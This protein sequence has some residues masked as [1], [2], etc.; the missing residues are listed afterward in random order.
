VELQKL[1][2]R[3]ELRWPGSPDDVRPFIW[4]QA[5]AENLSVDVEALMLWA[6]RL[7]VDKFWA[8]INNGQKT[9]LEAE[10]KKTTSRLRLSFN[11]DACRQLISAM[12]FSDIVRRRLCND[13]LIAGKAYFMPE[14]NRQ[15]LQSAI[16]NFELVVVPRD[17]APLRELMKQD[18]E[19]RDRPDSHYWLGIR[20]LRPSS[21]ATARSALTDAMASES[22]LDADVKAAF[23]KFMLRDG[24]TVSSD[25]IWVTKAWSAVSRNVQAIEAQANA[26]VDTLRANAEAGDQVS[27][28][29]IT[30]LA[31]GHAVPDY[32]YIHNVMYSPEKAQD[33]SPKNQFT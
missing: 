1:R 33:F 17:T 30:F 27:A 19:T 10:V 12:I 25:I 20:K 15:I 23:S 16:I 8:L 11:K 7:A 18:W 9:A 4:L 2:P 26:V 31:N 3:A 5:L 13:K 28:H 21:I 22:G 32:D 29:C 14:V 6:C 24:F